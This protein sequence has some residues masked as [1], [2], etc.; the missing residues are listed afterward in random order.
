MLYLCSECF[1]FVFMQAL[2]RYQEVT[3]RYRQEKQKV[4]ELL[5][6][7]EGVRS[8]FTIARSMVGSGMNANLKG[9]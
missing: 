5:K 2:A 1:L 4:E 6:E 7:R 8:S 9:D 3:N